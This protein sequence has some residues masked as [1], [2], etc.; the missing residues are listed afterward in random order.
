MLEWDTDFYHC[1][2]LTTMTLKF[3]AF[4]DNFGKTNKKI[5]IYY[6]TVVKFEHT[7]VWMPNLEFKSWTDSNC[8]VRNDKL[9]PQIRRWKIGFERSICA[10]KFKPSNAV[11]KVC[12][13]LYCPVSDWVT[14]VK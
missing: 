8:R 13:I 5:K 11:I 3:V 4:V 12:Y 1:H 6:W 9:V 14:T 7:L 10:S 2:F